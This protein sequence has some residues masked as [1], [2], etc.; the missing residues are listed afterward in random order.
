MEEGPILGL[1]QA[2]GRFTQETSLG[3]EGQ[4]RGGGEESAS[5]K[6]NGWLA[7][8]SSGTG[9]LIL[10]RE[11][12]TTERHIAIIKEGVPASAKKLMSG[13]WWLLTDND[14]KT[15]LPTVLNYYRD[16]KINR[17]PFPG[18]S[19][20][21]NVA[22]NVIKSLKDHVAARGPKNS[23]D[24]ERYAKE[25]WKKIP[26]ELCAD[27]VVSMPRRCQAVIDARGGATKY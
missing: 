27:L 14:P 2:R 12:L 1:L 17:M 23:E 15:V 26:K 20:D 6:I 11:N 24:L 25:E 5:P 9:K 7:V 21:V 19:P 16:N 10:F 4:D 22:E 13:H 18:Y 8:S 3:E